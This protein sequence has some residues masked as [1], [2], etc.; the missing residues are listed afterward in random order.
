MDQPREIRKR[1]T[2][3]P[4]SDRRPQLTWHIVATWPTRQPDMLQANKQQRTHRRSHSTQP[5]LCSRARP[6]PGMLHTVSSASAAKQPPLNPARTFQ[7]GILAGAVSG[8]AVDAILFPLDTLKTRLQMATG[9]AA[10]QNLFKGIYQGF[11]P[12]VLA[13]VRQSFVRGNASH[14][15]S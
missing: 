9:T 13:S 6:C 3:A 2:I 5:L 14:R 1:R 7:L 10:R 12:A 15:L 4:L 8:F 11:G